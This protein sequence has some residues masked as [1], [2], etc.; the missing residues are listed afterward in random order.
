MVAPDGSVFTVV[1]A[2]AGTVTHHMIEALYPH[3]LHEAAFIEKVM[4]KRLDF[5]MRYYLTF[6][7]GFRCVNLRFEYDSFSLWM[8]LLH[9]VEMVS[10]VLFQCRLSGAIMLID[11]DELSTITDTMSELKIN[12]TIIREP[13]GVDSDSKMNISYLLT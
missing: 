12:E 8:N 10:R 6:D 5:E 3:M 4:G 2:C 11:K 9:D 7:E 1:F 13:F